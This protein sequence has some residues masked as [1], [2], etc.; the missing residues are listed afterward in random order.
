MYL[1]HSQNSL[2]KLIKKLSA[3]E[4]WSFLQNPILNSTDNSFIKGLQVSKIHYNALLGA[5]GVPFIVLLKN[6]Y[7]P[8]HLDYVAKYNAWVVQGGSQQG[9]TLSLNQ[10]L[11]LLSN[12][13]I[14]NWDIAIQNVY[15][16]TTQ[17]YKELL[18]NKRAPFQTGKQNEKIAVVKAL[19]TAIGADT[20]LS[21][22]KIDVDQTYANL[23]DAQTGQQTD[24]H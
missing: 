15:D 19:G 22:V 14:R 1:W 18:P 3:M 21:A 6:A 23:T 16:N 7:E 11:R 10:L 24:D 4:T 17:R 13:K 8:I 2:K 9:Q 12:T 20:A 5:T